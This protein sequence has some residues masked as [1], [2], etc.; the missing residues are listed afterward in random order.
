MC[1]TVVQ[2]TTS[3]LVQGVQANHINHMGLLARVLG[4]WKSL[5]TSDEDPMACLH[6]V[7]ACTAFRL[8]NMVNTYL[9][10]KTEH[11]S[12]KKNMT[13]VKTEKQR[14]KQKTCSQKKNKGPKNGQD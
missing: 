12:V 13:N 1:R 5:I 3:W 6:E 10:T 14:R 8:L 2:A 11:V 7:T 4:W 9:N